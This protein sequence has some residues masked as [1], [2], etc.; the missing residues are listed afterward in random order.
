M[1]SEETEKPNP[2]P[3]HQPAPDPAKPIIP[4]EFPGTKTHRELIVHYGYLL[5]TR[6]KQGLFTMLTGFQTQAEE[7]K[8]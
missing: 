3:T 6:P 4:I 2:D 5:K 8:E 7:L 1:E